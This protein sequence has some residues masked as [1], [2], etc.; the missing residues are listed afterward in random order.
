MTQGLF[1]GMMAILLVKFA[2]NDLP[3]AA[4]LTG[5]PLGL[6]DRPSWLIQ[7]K[8][9]R[10]P[11]LYHHALYSGLKRIATRWAI[12]APAGKNTISLTTDAGRYLS[13]LPPLAMF[14]PTVD[15]VVKMPFTEDLQ[16]VAIPA[17]YRT[18]D[19]DQ[20]DKA[21]GKGFT[22]YTEDGVPP[23]Y[24]YIMAFVVHPFMF[25]D[26]NE[27]TVI[28]PHVDM[29]VNSIIY[30]DP[31]KLKRFKAGLPEYAMKDIRSLEELAR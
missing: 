24:Q 6:T 30:I 7:S 20:V 23:E 2:L 18:H 28:A 29:P 14:M 12:E 11:Y 13:P 9:P 22:V 15:G 21:R 17:L 25:V 16:R 1:S 8:P 26:E 5:N 3:H 19:Q 10:E 31:K 4:G 27:Y